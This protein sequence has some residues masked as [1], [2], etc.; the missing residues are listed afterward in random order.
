MSRQTQIN[1]NHSGFNDTAFKEVNAAIKSLKYGQVIITV[2][3]GRIVQ[4][5]KT[6]KIR[7][8]TAAYCEKGGGI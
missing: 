4:I 7:F 8:D 1:E 3:N 2:H 5:D 6:E